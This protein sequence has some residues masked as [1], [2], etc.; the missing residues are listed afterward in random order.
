MFSFGKKKHSE[1]DELVWGTIS[2]KV[3]T[4]TLGPGFKLPPQINCT[5]KTSE[6][7]TQDTVPTG[8]GSGDSRI[9]T[10]P[11]DSEVTFPAKIFKLRIDFTVNQWDKKPKPLGI[12]EVK[13]DVGKISFVSKKVEKSTR[14][15]DKK[16]D[17]RFNIKWFPEPHLTNFSNLIFS[18]NFILSV[19][20]K[21]PEEFVKALVL[22]SIAINK[23][24]DLQEAIVA[25]E[26]NKIK[27]PIIAVPRR[28]GGSGSDKGV[29]WCQKEFCFCATSTPPSLCLWSLPIK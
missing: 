13:V 6:G 26:L 19:L 15:A 5:V 16:I 1:L 24:V 22:F 25:S 14:D 23:V 29:F 28:F 4:V 2:L 17:M 11:D 7:L 3:E 21:V 27:I 9:F 12:I 8:R 20:P 10:F 18:G